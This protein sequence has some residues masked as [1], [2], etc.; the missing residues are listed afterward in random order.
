[1]TVT[2]TRQLGWAVTDDGY[3]FWQQ[4]DGSYTDGDLYFASSADLLRNYPAHLVRFCAPL[5]R[6]A[7]REDTR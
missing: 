1:M 3:T 6:T 5:F 4:P 7:Q 2:F